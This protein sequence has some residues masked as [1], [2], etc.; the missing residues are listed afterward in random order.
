VVVESR[1]PARV[2]MMGGFQQASTRAAS[3]PAMFGRRK[4]QLK[5]KRGHVSP[6]PQEISEIVRRGLIEKHPN[7]LMT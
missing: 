7:L 6:E 2:M 4:P 1:L 5:Q 3:S